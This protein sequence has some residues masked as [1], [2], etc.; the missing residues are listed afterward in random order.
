MCGPGASP[1]SIGAAQRG[2]KKKGKVKKF[3][4]APHRSSSSS[5]N[6]L[7][8]KHRGFFFRAPLLVCC[9]LQYTVCAV[10][11]NTVLV[12]LFFPSLPQQ[13]RH[14]KR[15]DRVNY[16][17]PGGQWKKRSPIKSVTPDSIA[18]VRDYDSPQKNPRY[19]VWFCDPYLELVAANW[20][21][22]CDNGAV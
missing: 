15:N 6:S 11:L 10:I 8:E 19:Y 14:R 7:L 1:L 5:H 20:H 12:S 2:K 3:F 9:H 18:I 17:Q 22:F 21:I 16:D 4:W 13:K